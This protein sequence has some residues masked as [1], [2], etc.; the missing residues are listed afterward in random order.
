MVAWAWTEFAVKGIK[1]SPKEEANGMV[2]I[3]EH[4]LNHDFS[5]FIKNVEYMALLHDV[6]VPLALK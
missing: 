4:I 6:Y 5:F 1:N 2:D 3:L